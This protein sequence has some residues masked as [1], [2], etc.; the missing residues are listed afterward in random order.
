MGRFQALQKLHRSLSGRAS[1]II[2]VDSY[3]GPLQSLVTALHQELHSDSSPV[4][5]LLRPQ[6]RQRHREDCSD[7]ELNFWHMSGDPEA[8]DIAAVVA[9]L[10]SIHPQS[11]SA[12]A[13]FVLRGESNE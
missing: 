10:C 7:P 3:S 12:P 8:R 11:L 1:P 4:I 5:I 13:P 2:A 9:T 6:D